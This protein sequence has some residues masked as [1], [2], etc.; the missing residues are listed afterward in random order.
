MAGHET[1]P[2]VVREEIA[3]SVTHGL[4]LLAGIAGTVV[5]VALAAERGE[6]WQVVSAAVYGTTLVALYGASTLYHALKGTKVR[7]TLRLLDH[8]AIYLLIAGT[9][10]PIALVGIPGG[11][12]W[13]IFGSVW[14]LATAGIAFK[15]FSGGRFSPISTGAYVAMGWLCIVAIKPI[16]EAL[17]TGALVWLL[18]GG[19]AY[20]AG[21]IFYHSKRVPYSHAVWHL[22]VVAGSV[23]HY[24]AIALYVLVPG[25]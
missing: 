10:T 12:G 15:I 6:T 4:G 13:A 8:C 2:V 16:F 22:F 21:M 3:N 11:W 9:Y 14:A 20:T 5:L 18:A 23:C 25:A 24:L 1:T 19:L 7:E 17:P